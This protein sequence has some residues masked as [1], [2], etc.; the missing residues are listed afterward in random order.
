MR[1]ICRPA[2]ARAVAEPALRPRLSAASAASLARLVLMGA[3]AAQGVVLAAPATHEVTI[4]DMRFDPPTLTVQAGD[5][6]TWVNK[7]LVPHTASA[8]AFDTQTI[9]PNASLTLTIEK[10]GSYAYAC[11][12][13][14]GMLG[15][16][17]V[18]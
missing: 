10:P 15:T 12:F 2:W 13:H 17:L 18:Q 4:E 8:P 5:S 14:P 16:L 6:V 3:L 11:R 7:D 9:A 1:A